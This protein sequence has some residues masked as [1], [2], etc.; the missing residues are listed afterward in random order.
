MTNRPNATS[1]VFLILTSLPPAALLK[2]ETF[3][4]ELGQQLPQS[5]D[6]IC[7]LPEAATGK[8]AQRRQLDFGRWV[9]GC[10]HG[11][12]YIVER[13]LY[14]DLNPEISELELNRQLQEELGQIVG[15]SLWFHLEDARR[16]VEGRNFDQV[17]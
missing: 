17:V 14:Y 7:I 16:L 4:T 6:V 12:L 3:L 10:L 9:A 13:Q 5:V 15:N 1:K 8:V 2:R 11:A